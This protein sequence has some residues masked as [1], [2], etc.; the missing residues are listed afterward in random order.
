MNSLKDVLLRVA[1]TLSLEQRLNSVRAAIL[2]RRLKACG[3][4]VDLLMPV[5]IENPGKVSIGNRVRIAP[6]VHIWGGGGVDIGS[7]VLIASHVSITSETHDAD[8][9]D[10]FGSHTSQKVVIEDGVWVGSHVVILPGVT[11]GSGAIAGACALVDKSVPSKAVVVGIPAK[12][13]RFR[14]YQDD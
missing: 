7:N 5:I 10:I 14:E 3:A 11:I 2:K 9:D 13:V 8:A 6:F 12:V 1:A 4:G